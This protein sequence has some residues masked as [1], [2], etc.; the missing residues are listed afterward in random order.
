[1]AITRIHPVTATVD[2]SVA[3]ICNPEKTDG[4]LMISSYACSPETAKYDFDFAL[5]ETGRKGKGQNHIAY[6]LIQSFAPGETTPEQAHEI[7]VKLADRLLEGNYSYVLATHIDKNHPHNHIIFC[8]ADHVHHRKYNDCKKSYYRIRK[9][10]DELCTE[11][12]L[13]VVIPSGRRGKK[14]NEWEAEKNGTSWK[15]MLRTDIDTAIRVARSYEAFLALLRTKG[16]EIKGEQIGEGAPKYISFR[17]KGKERFVRGSV[18]SLG[19]EYTKEAICER[20]EKANIR[21]EKFAAIFKKTPETERPKNTGQPAQVAPVRTT[22]IDT[23]A[24]RFQESS[25]LKKWADKQNLKTAASIYADAGSI[26]KLEEQIA[27]KKAEAKAA[28]SK[29]ASLD[30][31]LKE[32]KEILYYA[33]IYDENKK[34]NK[35]YRK[36]KNKEDYYQ[37]HEGNLILY[38]GA[39]TVL[40]RHKIDYKTMDVPGMRE[41]YENEQ[42][43][44]NET[45]DKYKTA[46]AEAK[47]LEK[48][49]ASLKQYLGINQSQERTQEVVQT[50]TKTRR[51]S[52]PSL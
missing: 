14:Y 8:A 21:R 1:M 35:G 26:E 9:L 4:F 16:Y 52:E 38:N 40:K 48:K 20:I 44:R 25:G 50:T 7:G 11:H 36:A 45:Y 46:Q 5:R 30:R 49:L 29:T 37:K 27:E 34:Y 10:S 2:K 23:S 42:D 3:Y 28:Y 32:H 13:S 22:L 24:S 31:T 15:Q 51:Q 41:Q 18:K 47:E 6:H 33:E 12:G 43:E 39:V 17:P 19:A